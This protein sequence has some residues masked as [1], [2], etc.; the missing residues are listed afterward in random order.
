MTLRDAVYERDGGECSSCHRDCYRMQWPP[1]PLEEHCHIG[2]ANF[3]SLSNLRRYQII[4]GRW[5]CWEV[6]HI[7]P[8]MLG[9]TDDLDNLATLCVWCHKRETASL[10]RW[11]DSQNVV[12]QRELFW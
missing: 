7:R 3:P 1:G 2:G 12:G 10:R 9:G 6:H 11:R 4:P 5:N 8:K